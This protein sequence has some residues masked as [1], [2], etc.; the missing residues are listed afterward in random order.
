M[1]Q[2]ALQHSYRIVV[3]STMHDRVAPAD[4]VDALRRELKLALAKAFGGYTEHLGIGGFVAESGE[5]IEEQV[6]VIEAC[7]QIAD[8]DLIVGLARRIKAELDQESVMIRKDNE[9][10]FV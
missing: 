10:Y 3:P 2:A 7:Y 5:L 6:Y 8:D 9:V 4:T 1:L